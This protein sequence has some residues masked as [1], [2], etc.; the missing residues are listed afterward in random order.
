MLQ[1][2]NILLADDDADDRYFFSKA[3]KILPIQSSLATVEDGAKLMQYLSDNSTQLPDALFLDLNMPCKNGAECLTEIKDTETL[4]HL[5]VI[6]YSTSLHDDIA[7]VL[8]K[9]GAHYYIRKG[10]LADLEKSLLEILTMMK[11][12]KFERPPKNK[13]I[14]SLLAI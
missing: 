14:L 1:K 4:K 8:Y 7:D 5:P 6:I 3:L 9:N 10:S 2:L 11:E 12:N 13:F